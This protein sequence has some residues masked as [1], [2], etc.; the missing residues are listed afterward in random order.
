MTKTQAIDLLYSTA[1]DDDDLIAALGN[2]KLW[3][4]PTRPDN[5]TLP[6]ITMNL[7]PTGQ[8]GQQFEGN[9]YIVQFALYAPTAGINRQP[10]YDIC[11]TVETRLLAVFLRKTF[12]DSTGKISINR[13]GPVQTLQPDYFGTA[14]DE[15]VFLFTFNAIVL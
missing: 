9:Q 10:D 7:L 13:S 15:T 1:K 8:S 5:A 3:K 14:P 12:A 4:S 6:A 11:G 2:G